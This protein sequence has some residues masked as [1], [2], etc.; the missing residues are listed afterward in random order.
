M[1]RDNIRM[2]FSLL[3]DLTLSE[4]WLNRDNTACTLSIAAR[5]TPSK[6]L[7]TLL[8]LVVLTLEANLSLSNQ[9]KRHRKSEENWRKFLKEL[10]A[11]SNFL[12]KLISSDSLPTI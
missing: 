11:Q 10:V 1:L 5:Q 12:R 6:T 7:N 8:R 4:S 9:L 2:H 3:R